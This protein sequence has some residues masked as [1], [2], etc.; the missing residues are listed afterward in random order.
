LHAGL[1]PAYSQSQ[2]SPYFQSSFECIR[3]TQLRRFTL[4]RLIG[5]LGKLDENVE[6]NVTFKL[7]SA[8]AHAPQ[9]T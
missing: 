7:R 8:G 2:P 3:N 1:R 4:D 6:V 5:I 9:P